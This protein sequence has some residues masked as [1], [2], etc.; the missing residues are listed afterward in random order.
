M[1]IKVESYNSVW[2]ERF[3]ILYD[4]IWPKVSE[5][6]MGIEHV[7]STSIEGLAAKP[8][9]DLDIIVESEGNVPQII[10]SLAELGYVHR[11]NLGIESREAF[12][13]VSPKFKHNL[14]VCIS[15]SI[16]LKNHIYLRNHLRKNSKDRDDYSKLKLELAR[17]YPNDIDS[18]VDGK[19]DFILK[20][21]NNY[22]FSDNALTDI[23]NANKK[24]EKV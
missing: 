23:E 14:Y 13:A 9:I 1:E 15:G 16:A 17:K 18:Y 10:N 21:L 7:G 6:A 11:G 20:I 22:H 8:I 2:K 19:T 12:H 24:Q 5:F 3:Q 4:K